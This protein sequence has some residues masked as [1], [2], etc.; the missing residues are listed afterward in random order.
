MEVI[1]SETGKDALPFYS[2][3]FLQLCIATEVISGRVRG[4]AGL[5]Y[6]TVGSF[7]ANLN[8]SID[9]NTNYNGMQKGLSGICVV[10]NVPLIMQ[11]KIIHLH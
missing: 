7:V 4:T 10:K 2:D 6:K 1:Y 11:Y 9:S 5:C 3:S 8:P